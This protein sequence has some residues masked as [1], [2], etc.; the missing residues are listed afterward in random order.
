MDFGRKFYR[1]IMVKLIYLILRIFWPG[2]FLNFLAYC[3]VTSGIDSNHSMIPLCRKKK[4]SEQFFNVLFGQFFGDELI[5]LSLY[6][7]TRCCYSR[8][9]HALGEEF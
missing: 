4:K 2:T 6:K 7:R 1:E 8:F 5:D 3:D 9:S